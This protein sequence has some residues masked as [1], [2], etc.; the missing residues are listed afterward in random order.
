[1]PRRRRWIGGC[2]GEGRLPAT[3]LG[4]W[5]GRNPCGAAEFA[6]MSRHM[7]PQEFE[8]T[9]EELNRCSQA[10]ESLFRPMVEQFRGDWTST[11]EGQ[12]DKAESFEDF[13]KR[14]GRHVKQEQSLAL[15]AIGRLPQAIPLGDAS[16]HE[17]GLER[18]SKLARVGMRRQSDKE[19]R[20]ES[21][22]ETPEVELLRQRHG[23]THS[24]QFARL[25]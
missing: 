1:M 16:D 6:K 14:E 11:E 17:F 23:G 22:A 7:Q 12:K 24:A 21:G 20:F 13:S 8:V 5:P 19:F 3:R 2:T 4:V 9:I 25:G 18:C 15:F 10:V